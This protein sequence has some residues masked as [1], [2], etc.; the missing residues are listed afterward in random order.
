[1]QTENAELLKKQELQINIQQALQADLTKQT[2]AHQAAEKA[3]AELQV[4]CEKLQAEQ[5]ETNYRQQLLEEEIHEAEAQL[6]L[7]KEL[8]LAKRNQR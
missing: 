3:K 8:L 7:L 1:M 4:K 5:Q 6:D 2:Q